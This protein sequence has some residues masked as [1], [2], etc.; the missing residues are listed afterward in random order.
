MTAAEAIAAAE[1]EGLQLQSSD[2]AAG[3]RG[4]RRATATTPRP[5]YA[6]YGPRTLGSYATAEEAAPATPYLSL[7]PAVQTPTPSLLESAVHLPLDGADATAAASAAV[8]K[9][10]TEENSTEEI[11][12]VGENWDHE[13]QK[14]FEAGKII[15]QT[16]LS[17]GLTPELPPLDATCD[18]EGN[19]SS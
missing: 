10:Q 6:T 19:R 9:F 8:A 3:F 1:A 17:F 11:G 16:A 13:K 7:A 4:V 15:L 14:K 18:Q 12:E 2:N 5:F